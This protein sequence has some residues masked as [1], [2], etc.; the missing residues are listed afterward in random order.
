MERIVYD[1]DKNITPP[2]S[3]TNGGSWF[4]RMWLAR[5]PTTTLDYPVG[6]QPK[7]RGWLDT[8][9]RLGEVRSLKQFLPLGWAGRDDD[10]ELRNKEKVGKLHG[11]NAVEVAGS[12]SSALLASGIRKDE[13]NR[14]L[15]ETRADILD[16]RLKSYTAIDYFCAVAK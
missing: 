5:N 12:W 14:W 4:S 2:A 3:E 16:M 11:I 9:S 6:P 8:D 7:I 1:E 10:I 15:K 13:L